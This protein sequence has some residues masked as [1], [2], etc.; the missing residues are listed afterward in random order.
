MYVIFYWIQEFNVEII[1]YDKDYLHKHNCHH[2]RISDICNFL[3]DTS[4]QRAN[5]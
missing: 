2:Q 1:Q 3:L 5:P 4:I